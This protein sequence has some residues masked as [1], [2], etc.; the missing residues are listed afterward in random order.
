MRNHLDMLANVPAD[1]PT[2]LGLI[3]EFLIATGLKLGPVVGQDIGGNDL[4]A[5]S[6][7][8]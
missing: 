4:V 1:F 3:H 8:R 7:S 6:R 2:A 5:T